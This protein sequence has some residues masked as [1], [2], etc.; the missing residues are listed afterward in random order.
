MSISANWVLY[1]LRR[2]YC[3]GLLISKSNTLWRSI[4]HMLVSPGVGYQ[5]ARPPRVWDHSDRESPWSTFGRNHN[6][7]EFSSKTCRLWDA[8]T[9]LWKNRQAT[10]VTDFWCADAFDRWAFR[11]L[12][13]LTKQPR[14][15]WRAAP[16]RE[17]FTLTT[18]SSISRSIATFQKPC[19][20]LVCSYLY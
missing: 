18:R 5:L 7:K 8:W 3:V 2:C 17:R 12:S 9:G 1:F 16:L 13:F 11:E 4:I 6:V 15:S 19:A 14:L 20:G 10:H